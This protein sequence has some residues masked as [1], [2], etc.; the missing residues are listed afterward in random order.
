MPGRHLITID[1]NFN[2]LDRLARLFGKQKTHY[3]GTLTRYSSSKSLMRR[4]ACGS[5]STEQNDHKLGKI[6]TIQ[7][8]NE[9]W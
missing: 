2:S 8:M 9:S 1:L 6:A 4:I 5:L 3:P 7:I